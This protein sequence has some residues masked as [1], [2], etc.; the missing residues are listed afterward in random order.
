MGHNSVN[1]VISVLALFTL[2]DHGLYLYQVPPNYLERLMSYRANAMSILIIT[3]ENNSINIARG[4][5]V[6]FLCTLSDHDLHLYQ[7]S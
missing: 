5:T 2:S 3:K 4:V 7:V 1:I 6:L